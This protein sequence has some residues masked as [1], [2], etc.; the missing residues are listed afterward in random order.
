MA[1]ASR[2][3]AAQAAPTMPVSFVGGRYQVKR[4][5]GEGGK[6]KVYLVHDTMLD[7]EVAFSLI[8]TEG[9]DEVGIA[10]IKQGAQLMGRLGDHPYVVSLYDIGDEEGQPYLVSQL[11]GGGDVEGLIEKAV[12]HRLT[13]EETFRIAD[14]LCQALHY[15]H[16]HGIVHRDLKPG[17]V[18]LT[19]D[20]TAKLGDFGLAMAVDK[21]RLSAAGMIVG[22]LPTCPPS[23]PSVVSRM[24]ARI[25]TRSGPC[26]TR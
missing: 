17:N 11:M 23:R 19:Q 9:L 18:W 12:E 8:K 10:R 5:L 13:L 16:S 4:F 14:Q 1:T 15:A 6:K 7:R 2:N 24:P 26:S 21:T 3:A 25:S 22:T 20:G